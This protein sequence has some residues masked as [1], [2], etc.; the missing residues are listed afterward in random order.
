MR[1]QN[2]FHTARPLP[3][4]N[5]TCLGSEEGV[6]QDARFES[7]LD[8]SPMY[9]SGNWNPSAA[10]FS[11][12]KMQLYDVGMASMHTM[13]CFAL[14]EL[15]AAIGRADD[16]AILRQRG[17]AMKTLIDDHLWDDTLGIYTNRFPEAHGLSGNFSPRV[18]PTSF[19]A[20]QTA[21][22]SAARVTRM[23]NGWLFN[24]QHFC[25][26]QSG[27]MAGNDESCFW[28]LPSIDRSDVAFKKLGY[29][30]GCE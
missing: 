18:S 14:A 2:W 3:P 24:K 26:A 16:A 9:D 28:G 10:Q 23:L 17:T 27:D 13:D 4:L 1:S 29:W 25:V 21:A 11:D 5:I 12:N 20:M 15:A 30:R 19:Y 7:G 8:N 22:P 6:M